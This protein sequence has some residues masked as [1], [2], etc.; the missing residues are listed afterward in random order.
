ME[1]NISLGAWNSVFAVPAAL[2]DEHIKM[3]GSA[4][5]K[6]LLYL[7]RNAGRPI[8]CQEVAAAISLNKADVEDALN[9]WVE[10]G[11]LQR[12]ESIMVPGNKEII[13]VEKPDFEMIQNIEPES[14]KRYI[15]S[16][17]SRPTPE[18]CAV[19]LRDRE[20]IKHLVTEA[21]NILGKILKRRD[22]DILVSIPDWT[23]MPV[24]VLIMAVSYCVSTGKKG[25]SNIERTALLWAE[26]E[27]DT[28]EKADKKISRMSAQQSAWNEVRGVTGMEY[29]KPSK[30]ESDFCDRWVNEW[31]F[32]N[33]MIAEAYE[34]CV[35]ATGKTSLNYMNTILESWH[36]N[37][38]S[39]MDSAS[40]ESHTRKG[41][42]G[43]TAKKK[44]S[45]NIDDI[46]KMMTSETLKEWGEN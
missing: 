1:Y 7:L 10:T 43:K 13:P 46:E 9:Y 16:L 38:I 18:E 8:D 14:K 25:I 23:G 36:K 4:Q 44:T 45:Y 27:I 19:L 12:K 34:R 5:L 26:E 31:G 37:G 6:A 29:R 33:E 20:D 30:K 22:I 28:V 2:V 42:G 21:Q 15:P 11:I 3:A 17:P 35:N 41:A 32:K 24:D 39:T 40:K